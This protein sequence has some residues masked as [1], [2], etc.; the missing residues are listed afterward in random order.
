[1]PASWGLRNAFVFVD[2]PGPHDPAQ[3]SIGRT[4]EKSHSGSGVD[5]RTSCAPNSSSGGGKTNAADLVYPQISGRFVV[6]GGWGIRTPEGFHPT[7]F[8]SVRHRPLGESSVGAGMRTRG[9]PHEMLPDFGSRSVHGRA[10]ASC[11]DIRSVSHRVVE[12]VEWTMAPR[13]APS[14]PTPPGRKRSKGNRAL[15][16]ARG[17]FSCPVT[18]AA[19][20]RAGVRGGFFMPR[21]TGAASCDAR[22]GARGSSSCLVTGGCVHARRGARGSFSCAAPTP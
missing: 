22:R 19:F 4:R 16:G 7:R 2:T 9:R 11:C 15:A 3:D 18:G 1:M 14:R 21:V 5:R 17:V 6:G 12:Q 10:D 20:M 13:V 8:P